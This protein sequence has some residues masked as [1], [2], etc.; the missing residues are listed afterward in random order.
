VILETQPSVE[1]WWFGNNLGGGGKSRSIKE[2]K[3]CICSLPKLRSHNILR[4]LMMGA[5]KEWKSV[6]KENKFL[7]G[8]H[9]RGERK[10][11]FTLPLLQ[12]YENCIKYRK[13]NTEIGICK[14]ERCLI[15]G[16]WYTTWHSITNWQK[17]HQK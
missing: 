17:I 8:S 10:N 3:A 13:T 9:V 6:V 16:N 11:I 4:N 15:K 5:I 7:S 1:A 12:A 14:C 2:R